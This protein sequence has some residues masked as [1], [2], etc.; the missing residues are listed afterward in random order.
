M[1]EKMGFPVEAA[2]TRAAVGDAPLE[3]TFT[4]LDAIGADGVAAALRRHL[5]EQGVRGV[6]RGERRSTRE[7]PAGLTRRQAE[8]L[9]LLAEGMTN[10][11]IAQH[12]FISEKTASHHVSAILRKLG[13]D[14]RGQAI[15]WAVSTGRALN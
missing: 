3:A 9:T 2:I 6:P 15:A 10:A 4:Q 13:V 12:L 1:W 8:V 5:R 11:A 7:N 14:N